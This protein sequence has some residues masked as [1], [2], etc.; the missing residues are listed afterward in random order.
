MSATGIGL[1]GVAS[2]LLAAAV[3]AQYSIEWETIDGGGETASG[4]TY[5][6]SGTM[7]QP[8]AEAS[9]GGSYELLG[10][11][12]GGR[13]IQVAGGPW[14]EIVS[15]SATNVVVS[16]A[17]DPAGWV[18][19]F[20]NDLTTNLWTDAASGITNPIS[21]LNAEAHRFYRLRKLP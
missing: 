11:F 14:L 5:T 4:G 16:W 20:N 12:W 19:Q 13:A 2:A 15:S 9:V 1:A 6:L 17:P 3:Y 7:G 10:G 18:L 8:D 21:I